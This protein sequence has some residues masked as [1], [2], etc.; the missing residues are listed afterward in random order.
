MRG[1]YKAGVGVPL[2]TRKTMLLWKESTEK[3]D[4]HAPKLVD[5]WFVSYDGGQD[6]GKRA[7]YLAPGQWTEAQ[8]SGLCS[9]SDVNTP[10]VN[11]GLRR[12][13]EKVASS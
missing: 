8:T 10:S 11:R 12:M 1:C 3:G 6:C 2:D 4:A 13:W 5:D 7:R 9:I